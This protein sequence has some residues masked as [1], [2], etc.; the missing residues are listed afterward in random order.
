MLIQSIFNAKNIGKQHSLPIAQ[1]LDPMPLIVRGNILQS[2]GRVDWLPDGNVTQPAL[3]FVSDTDT[4]FYRVS[5]DDIAIST[6]G[7]SRLR[8]NSD[9][10][11]VTGNLDVTG[12]ITGQGL[13]ADLAISN[14]QIC[15]SSWTPVDDTHVGLSEGYILVNGIGLAPGSAVQIGGVNAPAVSYV[16]DT[17]LRVQTPAKSTGTYNVTVVRGDTKTATLTSA[18]SYSQD[19]VFTTASTLGSVYQY[20]PFTETITATSD[21]NVLYSNITAL[22]IQTTLDANSG[23]LEANIGVSGGNVE[24]LFSFDLKAED[25]EL[26]DAIQTF[27]L[28]YYPFA[29]GKI[30]PNDSEASAIFGHSCSISSDGTRAIVA[31]HYDDATGGADSG[32]AYIFVQDGSSWVQESKLVPSDS[33]ADAQFGYSCSISSDG[34]RAIVGAHFDDATGGYNSGAAY[35]FTRSGTSWVQ[36]S[37]LVPSD[38]EA[39]AR[40]GNSCS[41]SSDGT[42]AIVGARLDDATGGLNSGAA[43]VFTRSG[44]SWAQEIKLVPSDSEVSAYFGNSCSISSDGTRAIVGAYLDDATGGANSG[45]AYVFTRSGTSWAQEIKLVPSDSEAD[46]YFGQSCSISSDGT[47]AIVGA[48]QDD[49]TGGGNSGAAYLFQRTYAGWVDTAP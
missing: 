25:E 49:A 32:A 2:R 3:T 12:F 4:G 42:R 21:S 39:G 47:C 29:A 16:S 14:V 5:N 33:E 35:V 7:V 23:L 40:F 13:A 20:L 43:Y 48:H 45:A 37:K 10:V 38:S 41:I 17:Q 18:I 26:Q 6:G 9:G 24:T 46:A 44:T 31:A 28:Q 22:P 27:L 30:V 36:E 19:V 11:A 34:T 8:L 1:V 15:D